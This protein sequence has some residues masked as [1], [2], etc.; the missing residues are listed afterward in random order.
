MDVVQRFKE[1]IAWYQPTEDTGTWR[2]FART[3][4]NVDY[5]K[6]T[7]EQLKR[8]AWEGEGIR[9]TVD[10]GMWGDRAIRLNRF[11]TGNMGFSEFDAVETKAIEYDFVACFLND[12][13]HAAHNADLWGSFNNAARAVLA[14]N[15]EPKDL[16]DQASSP[17]PISPKWIVTAI[18]LIL[19]SAFKTINLSYYRPTEDTNSWAYF[20]AIMFDLD[21]LPRFQF[22]YRHTYLLSNV[23]ST[24][25]QGI[26]STM[27]GAARQ[28]LA[29]NLGKT[30]KTAEEE[31]ELAINFCGILQFNYTHAA[32]N[33]DLFKAYATAFATAKT[34][35]EIAKKKHA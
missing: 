27:A 19:Y 28:F 22:V 34:K 32:H 21:L 5:T 15:I 35:L 17:N 13:A 2:E 25:D 24:V 18:P 7:V 16:E 20:Q 33:E 3:T 8:V 26:W 4:Y 31:F 30:P 12:P 14:E 1:K 9:S 23:T 6:A 10:R 29:A 11:L